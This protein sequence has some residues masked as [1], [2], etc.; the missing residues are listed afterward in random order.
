MSKA[1]ESTYERKRLYN[2]LLQGR[3]LVRMT[4][5][6]SSPSLNFFTH[7]PKTQPLKHFPQRDILWR[8]ARIV[9]W[10][11]LIRI[12]AWQTQWVKKH[13]CIAWGWCI[14][15]QSDRSWR[16]R[17]LNLLIMSFQCWPLTSVPQSHKP[18]LSR[19]SSR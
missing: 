15:W 12:S 11:K 9:L 10:P 8:F 4:V 5:S 13:Y 1:R 7:S 14:A 2:S 17:C 3:R 6:N 19:L 16:S 18:S